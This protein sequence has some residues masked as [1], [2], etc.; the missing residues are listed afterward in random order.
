MQGVSP[1]QAKHF[2]PA[3]SESGAYDYAE[4]V[5]SSSVSVSSSAADDGDST[6]VESSQYHEDAQL[7]ELLS[8][9]ILQAA[10][11][12]VPRPMACQPFHPE[13]SHCIRAGRAQ[14]PRQRN[15]ALLCRSH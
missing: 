12:R 10:Q 7:G 11:V 9:L 2:P 6:T 8:D 4:V 3:L 13:F 5:K 14:P 15:A 1:G